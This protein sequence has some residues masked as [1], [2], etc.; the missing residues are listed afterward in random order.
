L[1]NS[2]GLG[3][4]REKLDMDSY[5]ERIARL[6]NRY[7]DVKKMQQTL[8][9]LI[10]NPNISSSPRDFHIAELKSLINELE[11]LEYEIRLLQQ[12]PELD[13]NFKISTKLK[14]FKM[15]NGH[16]Q[17]DINRNNNQITAQML[18]KQ[19]PKIKKNKTT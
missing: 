18:K 4:G 16:V 19:Q 17:E 5:N 14:K 7:M 10:N 9:G 6:K 1:D 15:Q 2:K 8:I 12:P 13:N 11:E 3:L